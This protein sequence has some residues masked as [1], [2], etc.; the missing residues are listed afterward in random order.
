MFYGSGWQL[1]ATVPLFINEIKEN[2]FSQGIQKLKSIVFKNL[3]L[4]IL[5]HL[6]SWFD[7]N[8]EK[9]YIV[10]CFFFFKLLEC[11]ISILFIIY[12]L[13]FLKDNVILKTGVMAAKKIF[14]SRQ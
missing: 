7:Q 13:W 12:L 14:L 10:N 11:Q 4:F 2:L 9:V 5:I 1:L 6:F 8:C 3:R